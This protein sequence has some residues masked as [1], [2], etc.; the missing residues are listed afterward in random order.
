MQYTCT[1]E[2][3]CIL[4]V[5]VTC[6]WKPFS[7]SFRE[8]STSMTGP[9]LSPPFFSSQWRSWAEMELSSWMQAR[10]VDL[11]SLMSS[12]C[13]WVSLALGFNYLFNLYIGVVPPPLRSL[14]SHSVQR[15]SVHPTKHAHPLTFKTS[16]NSV[17]LFAG[18]DALGWKKLCTEFSQPSSGSSKL[19]INS[20][21]DGKL[22]ILLIIEDLKGILNMTK[23]W[24]PF[25]NQKL[26]LYISPKE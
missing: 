13:C 1:Y 14:L 17:F 3:I 12:V 5:C 20:T 26:I 4:C 19:C 18:T 11:L 2:S 21:E 7:A 24:N 8:L 10:W 23:T 25:S 16:Q 22:F 9:Y 6:I 15:F